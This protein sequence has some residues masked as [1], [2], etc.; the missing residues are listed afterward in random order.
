MATTPQQHI[1]V[2]KM[3]FNAE[4]FRGFTKAQFVQHAKEAAKNVGDER[5]CGDTDILWDKVQ[6]F[7]NYKPESDGERDTKPVTGSG[8]N[9]SRGS[10]AANS[11]GSGADGSGNKA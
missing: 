2:G 4:G 11:G 7:L 5:M 10:D 6:A 9:N 3:Q 1:K 8:K